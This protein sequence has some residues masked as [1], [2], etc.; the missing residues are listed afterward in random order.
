MTIERCRE[1][2]HDCIR[3]AEL[4]SNPEL[5]ERLLNFAR[6]WTERAKSLDGKEEASATSTIEQTRR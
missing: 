3:R 2:A 5:R 4:V 1:Y 6:S